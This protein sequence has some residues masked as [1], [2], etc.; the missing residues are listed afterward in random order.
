MA[1][2][3][4]Y[5]WWKLIA[6]ALSVGFG[7]GLPAA[8]EPHSTKV[9]D[10][11]YN[12][13]FIENNFERAVRFEVAEDISATADLE[14]F[15]VLVRLSETAVD[16]FR[17]SD[18]YL[19]NG[20]GLVFLDSTGEIVPHE[21]DTWNPSGESLIW[22]RLPKVAKGTVFSMSYRG[23]LVD[24]PKSAENTF[25]AY[26]GVWHLN[27]TGDGVQMIVGSTTN[28]FKGETHFNS[29]CVTN[30]VIGGA[31]RVAQ[32]TGC[33]SSFGRI[34]IP[35]NETGALSK[36]GTSFTTSFWMQW[37]TDKSDYAYLVSR[38]ETDTDASWGV[39]YNAV[40]GFDSVRIWS[41]ESGK[42]NSNTHV[43]S[44][45]LVKLAKGWHHVAFVYDNEDFRIYING[46]EAASAKIEAASQGDNG[47]LVL[48][49]LAAGHGAFNGEL[50]EARI[51]GKALT[52]DWIAAEYATEHNVG[53][54]SSA[55]VYS[56]AEA[57][58]P[59]VEWYSTGDCDTGVID[60]SYAYVQFSGGIRNCGKDADRCLIL[61][62]LW[63]DGEK[64]A[65]GEGWKTL[66]ADLSQ[67]ASFSVPVTGL[68]H[69]MPYNYEICAV[70]N[71]TTQR[72]SAIASGTFRTL[73]HGD[74]G[75]GGTVTRY[76]DR[77]VH[78][79]T[80]TAVTN[81]FV[82]PAYATDVDILVVGGGGAGGYML[83]G[84]GGGGGVYNLTGRP[85]AT[86]GTPY[87]IVVGK[88]GKASAEVGTLGENGGESSVILGDETLV[89]MLGGGAGGNYNTSDTAKAKGQKGASGGG[90]SCG[91]AGG[92]AGGSF[93]V[94]GG[95]GSE[96]YGRK[97][98]DGNTSVNGG[99]S[100]VE[101]KSAAGGGG[102]IMRR[103]LGGTDDMPPA[104]GAGG[105]GV[106]YSINGTPQYYG[107]GGGGGVRYMTANGNNNWSS[108]G[109][110]GSSVG[111]D[112][113]NPK[114]KIPAT[115]GV[116]NTGSGGGGGS[117]DSTSGDGSSALWQGGDGADGIVV[118]SYV[119]HGQDNPSAEPHIELT[120]ADYTDPLNY[121]ATLGYRVDWAGED[122]ET[123]NVYA[124]YSTV[125]NELA[126]CKGTLVSLGEL[127]GTG[128]A[129][130]EV[131]Y[132]ATNFFVR[133]KAENP[134]KPGEFVYSDEIRNF[135]VPGLNLHSAKWTEAEDRVLANG[136][137]EFGYG[138]HWARELSDTV[139]LELLWS[140]N[141]DDLKGEAT[142]AS[143]TAFMYGTGKVLPGVEKGALQFSDPRFERGKTYYVR[144]RAVDADGSRTVLSP[145]IE[146]FV[147][148]EHMV[149]LTLG[150]EYKGGSVQGA[151]TTGDSYPE[152]T[153]VT[154]TATPDGGWYIVGW[155]I[156]YSEEEL[157][158]AEIAPNTEGRTVLTLVMMQDTWILPVFDWP[159][160]LR[161]ARGVQRYPW[162]NLVDID[163]YL[164]QDVSNARLVFFAEID[165]KKIQLKT[166]RD[167]AAVDNV[168]RIGQQ[169][170]LLKEGWHRVTWDAN[171]DGVA[172]ISKNV[173]YTL[174]I[175]EGLER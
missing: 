7:Y 153:Q 107:A 84:G 158:T 27:E 79:F 161:V 138:F 28:Q 170:D 58:R 39:Q 121:L 145:E 151:H 18:L 124:L 149:T 1:N 132:T 104:G 102:G 92:E 114:E 130:Y 60:L 59:A 122:A 30:G 5:S 119:V 93:G 142:G 175:C 31:R 99:G 144:L 157:A 76:Q 49:G 67:D 150:S 160:D 167:N 125:S 69:D 152:K 174:S 106:L 29:L 163:Y 66:V 83:G 57:E 173:I 113:A 171:A 164:A 61:Y 147:V 88:G 80:D 47:P 37:K 10:G 156:A 166:F 98:G 87:Q 109:L 137:A 78:V 155:K 172:Q 168:I 129:N 97:G 40:E 43:T 8:D 148:A 126:E 165:G 34:L 81:R 115:S 35:D 15:P 86:D 20:R 25:S 17:Y 128:T 169:S 56:G 139:R 50:D 131:S 96:I 154:V 82:A 19:R 64:P 63:R 21:I 103:G 46:S 75:T 74:P 70:N 41:N 48:G 24:V 45:D 101:N 105:N 120:S 135:N 136:H 32:R 42:R 62:R 141:V 133:L 71:A 100:D 89:N 94:V 26:V 110:G 68:D 134:N 36:I 116:P 14:N 127:I 140:A 51:V 118:I 143:V 33:S 112:A 3:T 123:C 38:K 13:Y 146:S 73:G 77:Y 54:L 55:K 159:V 108:A 65:D 162:N 72:L 117:I 11:I 16:G 4:R 23:S 90:G 95:T 9:D 44:D 2:L 111:G 91:Q 53:F 12:D 85:V 22:V 6:V 52:A